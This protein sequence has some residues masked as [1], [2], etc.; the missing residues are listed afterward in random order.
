MTEKQFIEKLSQE[1]IVLSDVQIQ[2]FA[3]YARLLV[4]WNEKMNLT[5][6]TALEEIYEKHF[7]SDYEYKFSSRLADYMANG[8]PK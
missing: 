4:E 7:R 1:G 2:Q 6:I 8:L 3:D 5:A